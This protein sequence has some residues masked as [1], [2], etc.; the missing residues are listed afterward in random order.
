MRIGR[1]RVR[2]HQLDEA[3]D[4]R[5]MIAQEVYVMLVERD[6]SARGNVC[7]QFGAGGI[8]CAGP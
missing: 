1:G 2:D 8:I 4:D 5:E 3:D 6:R 7:T